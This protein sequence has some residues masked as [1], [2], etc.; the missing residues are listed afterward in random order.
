MKEMDCL[1]C[2]VLRLLLEHVLLDLDRNKE[3]KM[4]LL[5]EQ[6]SLDV[7]IVKCFVHHRLLTPTEKKPC[8]HMSGQFRDSKDK[9][10]ADR[11]RHLGAAAEKSPKH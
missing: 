9:P 11:T 8:E 7:D 10:E 6:W 5:H 3:T 4:R 2:N 1:F